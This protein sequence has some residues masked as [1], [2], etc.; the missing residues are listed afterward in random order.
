M[1]IFAI[2]WNGITTE[3]EQR[4]ATT[5]DYYMSRHIV[6]AEQRTE[7]L[8]NFVWRHSLAYNNNWGTHTHTHSGI[9]WNNIGFASFICISLKWQHFLFQPTGQFHPLHFYRFM[10][11]ESILW[12]HTYEYVCTAHHTADNRNIFNCSGASYG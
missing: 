11:C 8:I 5:M 1:G 7:F 3:R 6:A 9:V 12:G 2:C 10:S 4:A